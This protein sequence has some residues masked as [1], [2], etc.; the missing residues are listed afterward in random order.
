MDKTNILKDD[1][2]NLKNK[3]EK[4]EQ[5]LEGQLKGLED[6]ENRWKRMDEQVV[7]L[8]SKQNSMVI[9]NIGGKRYKT[10]RDTLLSVKDTLFY[11]ALE[12]NKFGEELFFDRDHKVFPIILEYLRFKKIDYKRFNKRE[13]TQLYLEAD[14]YEIIDLL[15]QLSEYRKVIE[16]VKFEFSGAYMSGTRV[17]GTNYIEDLKDSSCTKGIAAKAPGYITI[18]LNA[19]WEFEEIEVGGLGGYTSIFGVSNGANAKILTS[20]DGVSWIEVGVLPT[21]HSNKVQKVKLKSS[22]ARFIKFQATTALGIGYLKI[23]KQ[24][25]KL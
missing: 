22:C 2:V 8:K 11:K 25:L 10:R 21:T 12:S 6:R 19:E 24:P 5:D 15:D 14:Y 18:Q 13:I 17:A 7:D 16:F 9:L 4:I 1:L 20:K 23:L 3:L